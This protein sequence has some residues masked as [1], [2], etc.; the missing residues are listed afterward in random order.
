MSSQLDQILALTNP[1]ASLVSYFNQLRPASWR[2]VPFVVEGNETS[3]GRRTAEH[4]YPYRDT[5][6]IEDLGR[7]PRKFQVTGFLV[8]DDVIQQRDNMLTA[9]EQPGPGTLV[10]PTFGAIT[11]NLVEPVSFREHKSHGRVIELTFSFEQSGQRLFPS[12]V[13]STGSAVTNAASQA[14]QAM[15]DDFE[16]QIGP[17]VLQGGLIALQAARTVSGWVGEAETLGNDSTNIFH[18]AAD[19]NGPFGR[20]F[21][22]NTGSG[23]G[24]ITG[25]YVSPSQIASQIANLVNTGA[26]DRANIG[27]AAS[28]VLST[29]GAI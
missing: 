14:N 16:S 26:Q 7:A 22:G 25:A 24:S 11:L 19:F 3:A 29:A 10:H 21:G 18:L 17:S 12:Q 13:I 27:S 4:L 8:G 23:S 28:K 9:A 1:L 6:W 20:F 2:G 5:P 15:S